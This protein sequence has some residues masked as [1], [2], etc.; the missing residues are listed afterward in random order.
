MISTIGLGSWKFYD[1]LKKGVFTVVVEYGRIKC[2]YRTICGLNVKY[3]CS[4][5]KDLTAVKSRI[6]VSGDVCHFWRELQS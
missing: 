5:H 2:Q 6:F 1:S 3:V 4:L